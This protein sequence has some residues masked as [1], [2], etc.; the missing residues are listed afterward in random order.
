MMRPGSASAWLLALACLAATTLPAPLAAQSSLEWAAAREHV[1]RAEL[2]ELRDQLESY[3]E[4]SAYS[5]RMRGDAQR[6]IEVI[7]RR[8]R[9]GDFQVGDRVVLE[10][11]GEAA[12]SDTLRVMPG[13]SLDIPGAGVLQ[14][15]GVL[16]AELQ[17]AMERQ[18]SEYIRNP[19][20]RTETLI[21]LSVMGAVGQPGFYVVPAHVPVTDVLM[22]A[23]GPATDARLT[24]LHIERGDDRIWA[25]EEMETAVIQ[26]RTLDQLNVQAGD[27]IV[28]PRENQRDG[29][30]TARNIVGVVGGVISL[31]FAL[32][33]IF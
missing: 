4:S 19:V 24:E 15:E 30:R 1:T 9:E 8:L 16:R 12:M 10:V 29:W 33:Q 28:V 2:Q 21:R 18:I 13:R 20:V 26:G 7:D 32:G 25:G 11:Q 5:G 14:L 17:E 23:G 6:T 3:S 27:R 22:Q 31:A